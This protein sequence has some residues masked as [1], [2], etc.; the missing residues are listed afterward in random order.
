MI[1]RNQPINTNNTE[2]LVKETSKFD[3][4][5]ELLVMK[6][7]INGTEGQTLLDCRANGNFISSDFVKTN[8]IKTINYNAPV[9]VT[10]ADG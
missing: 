10:L 8:K 2:S 6:T 5:R 3:L 4:S 7:W 1:Q 9:Q